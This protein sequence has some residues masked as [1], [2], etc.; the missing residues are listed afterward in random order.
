MNSAGNCIEVD[1]L[2]MTSTFFKSMSILRR[3]DRY[4]S[5]GFGYR[6]G[7]DSELFSDEY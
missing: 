5:I 6:F 4:S 2:L 3:T 7:L 1:R